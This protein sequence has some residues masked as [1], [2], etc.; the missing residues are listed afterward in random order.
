MPWHQSPICRFS[1]SCPRSTSLPTLPSASARSCTT[2]CGDQASRRCGAITKWPWRLERQFPHKVACD[3]A[4]A[5]IGITSAFAYQMQTALE[6]GDLTILLDEFW[7]A[8]CSAWTT[9]RAA[10]ASSL[11]CEGYA[12][13]KSSN[14]TGEQ[15]CTVD[16]E[17]ARP[18]AWY[19]SHT[20]PRHCSR[21]GRWV[22]S[23]HREHRAGQCDELAHHRLWL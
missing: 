10:A 21:N 2:I 14:A 23:R 4:C 16:L 20:C 11:L 18:S 6:C 5:G 8:S 22:L 17:R 12:R 3:A 1:R 13:S 15:H 9:N 19:D 7:P